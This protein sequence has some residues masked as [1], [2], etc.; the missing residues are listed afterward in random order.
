M[1]HTVRTATL[2]SPLGDLLLTARDGALAEIALMEATPE[3]GR[4]GAPN[5]WPRECEQHEER[6]HAE[7]PN[8][9]HVAAQS[10]PCVLPIRQR[11]PRIEMFWLADFIE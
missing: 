4:I 5:G 3:C 8:G 7:R 6:D 10:L 2:S 1:D 11:R 9:P